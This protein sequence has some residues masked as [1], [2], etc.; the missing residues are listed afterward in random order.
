MHGGAAGTSGGG[1]GADNLHSHHHNHHQCLHSPR[2]A[3]GGSSMTRRANSFKRG[4][5]EL[6]VGSPRSPRCDGLGS[7]P[8]D[9]AEPSAAGLHHH[10][11]QN[12]NLRFRLFKRP[13]SGAG[14]IDAGLGLGIRERRKLGNVLF[15]AFCSI[16]LLLGLGK[17]WAGG[18]FALP[19][20]DKHADFQVR[21]RVNFPA[22]S[23]AICQIFFINCSLCFVQRRAPP[24]LCP[25][26]V[27]N[28]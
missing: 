17:I 1:G 21:E 6:Q 20:D 23:A 24:S 22:H 26:R 25:G 2:V 10:H 12:S 5:I 7:P 4:E 15:L 11:Q 19:A 27:P 14:A 9:A 13:G 3:G 8:G 18:W 16:C 28:F